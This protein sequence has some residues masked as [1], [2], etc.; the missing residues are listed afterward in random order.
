MQFLGHGH[1][2]QA[3]FRESSFFRGAFRGLPQYSSDR[4][5]YSSRSISRGIITAVKL[6]LLPLILDIA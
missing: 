1:R 4:H 2:I 6:M 5:T 3:L